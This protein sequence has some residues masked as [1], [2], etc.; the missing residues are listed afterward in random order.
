MATF[1]LIHGSWHWGGCFVKVANI[2]AA[3]GHAVITPDLA[4]HGFDPT[5]T[6]AVTDLP[7]YAAPVRAALEQ[8]KGKAI[9]V[10]HSVGGATC[11]PRSPRWSISP[12]SWRRPARA[13]A[14]SS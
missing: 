12:A 2:L 5:P 4:S 7:T 8:V 14:I 10:G 6:H 9:L 13:P 11:P 1:I 3:N